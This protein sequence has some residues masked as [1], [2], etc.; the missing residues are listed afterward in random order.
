MPTIS[1]DMRL[2]LVFI[3]AF[4]FGAWLIAVLTVW[5]PEVRRRN[6]NEAMLFRLM[7]TEAG[8][9]YWTNFPRGYKARVP[10]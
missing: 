6:R 9:R 7:G 2:D 3:A 1:Y 8:V 4:V 10:R 5:L